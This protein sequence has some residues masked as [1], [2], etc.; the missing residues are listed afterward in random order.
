MN[1]LQFENQ[2]HSIG[3]SHSGNGGLI[4]NHTVD[5]HIYLQTSSNAV[6]HE[7]DAIVSALSWRLRQARGLRM[8]DISPEHRMMVARAFYGKGSPEDCKIALEHAIRF[9]RVRPERIQEYCDRIGRIGIDC[10][11]FVNNYFLA[12]GIISQA[13]NISHYTS[14]KDRK[15]LLDIQPDDVIIWTNRHGHVK[16]HPEAHIAL[17]HS[18]PDLQGHATIVE[19]AHSLHGLTHSSYIFS[20]TSPGVFRVQ[21]PSGH[22]FV[23][24]YSVR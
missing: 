13:K 4:Y 9:N 23:K 16:T 10:S 24:V 7:K 6:L 3:V 19:S 21:R 11:G 20:M 22:G 14:G 5:V 18:P 12:K 15:S 17:V 8:I 2:Y 1:P